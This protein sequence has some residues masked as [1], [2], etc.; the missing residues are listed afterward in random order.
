MKHDGL[1]RGVQELSRLFRVQYEILL[2]L[3]E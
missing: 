2:D 1:R 3:Q